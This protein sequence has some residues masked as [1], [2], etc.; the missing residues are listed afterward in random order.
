MV[1]GSRASAA[2]PIGYIKALVDRANAEF[3][4]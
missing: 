4:A 2:H 1:G 3:G